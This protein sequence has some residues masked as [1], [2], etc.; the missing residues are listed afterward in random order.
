M[1]V[2]DRMK[3][4]GEETEDNILASEQMELEIAHIHDKIS[5]FSQMVS[6]LKICTSL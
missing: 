4:I 2:D 5:R 1:S 3:T 6:L